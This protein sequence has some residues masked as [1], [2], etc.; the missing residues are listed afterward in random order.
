MKS[1]FIYALL[2][3]DGVVKFGSTQN[4]KSRSTDWNIQRNAPIVATIRSP[5][6]EEIYRRAERDLLRRASVIFT[7]FNARNSREYF[8][9][10]NFG[11]AR[12]LLFQFHKRFGTEPTGW[13]IK[14][15]RRIK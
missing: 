15:M 14:D 9:C 13:A 11:I 6:I 3:A 7:Q 12:N 10:H 1:G 2:Y 4:F 5:R 8:H